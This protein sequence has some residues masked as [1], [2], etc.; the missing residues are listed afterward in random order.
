MSV[1]FFFNSAI[2]CFKVWGQAHCVVQNAL[3]GHSRKMKPGFALSLSYEGMSLLHRAAGGWRL[4]GDVALDSMDMAGDLAALRDKALLLE[5]GGLHCKIILP[6]DQIR[7]LSVETGHFNGEARDS[8]VRSALD[9][10]TPYA[11]DDLAYDIAEDGVWTHIAAVARETLAEAEAFA[12]DHQFNPVSFVAVPDDNRFL[13]EPFF[14]VTDRAASLPEEGDVEPDGIAVVVVGPAEI[15]VADIP[16][17]PVPGNVPESVPGVAPDPIVAGFTSRRKAQKTSSAPS[18]GGAKRDVPPPVLP[19]VAPPI[20]A[21]VEVAAAVDKVEP[22]ALVKPDIP[23][24]ERDIDPLDLQPDPAPISV[25]EPER[26]SEFE[27]DIDPEWQAE[28]G[29]EPEP[30]YE[31]ASLSVT[32]PTLDIPEFSNPVPPE[33]SNGGSVFGRFLSRRSKTGGKPPV[34]VAPPKQVDV[35]PNPVLAPVAVS[36]PANTAVI[37]DG[38]VIGSSQDE[39]DRMTV[40]GAR[41]TTKVGGKPRYLGLMLTFG[42]LLFLAGVAAWAAIFLDDGVAGLFRSAKDE[43]QLA[44][45]PGT[46]TI[47]SPGV[48]VAPAA[49]SVAPSAP[50]QPQGSDQIPGAT[51]EL[52]ALPPARVGTPELPDVARTGEPDTLSPPG[53]PDTFVLTDTDSAVLDA[54]NQ[55]VPP[56]TQAEPDL[57]PDADGI[58]VG[59]ETVAPEGSPEI[60]ARYAATGIWQSAPQEP[61]TPSIIG[62]N[63]L[64]V[65]SIDRTDIGQDAVALPPAAGYATDLA[66]NALSSPAAAGTAFDLNERGLVVAT[67]AG[68]L[69]PDG[70]MIFLGRPPVVPPTVPT[71]FETE[72]ETD[73]VRD[74]LASLRPRLRPGD[75]G[76]Q[77]ER[78]QLGG[79]TRDELSGLR[80]KARP[81]TIKQEVEK[82]ETPTAAAVAA[83]RLP[84]PRPDNFAA[85]VTKATPSPNPGAGDGG[86]AG[87]SVASVA[88]RTVTPSIPSSAS[89][90]RQA[91]LN[92]AINLRRVNLI[93][94]YG[95]PSNRRALVRLPSGRYKKVKV[96]DTVDGGRVV[97]IGDTELRYQKGGR[98]LTLKI[99]SG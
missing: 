17:D 80:P 31:P 82:D 98:N 16:P 10:A 94:V 87:Q 29:Q 91:T 95:T 74:R 45:V 89:V 28:F 6:N 65:A 42:L 9:G 54:L 13:G 75:L 49:V 92:N 51:T 44:A 61:D 68:T 46:P 3:D 83:S 48:A 27:E 55:P 63:D 2:S 62:L 37:G 4:V 32:A 81:N 12:V 40:F 26:A 99:P 19:A 93:G 58:E 1:V 39:A 84:K 14:G 41:Q 64:Y 57:E 21:S 67:A 76:Q 56:D 86:R 71:R 23:P 72:P 35:P 69:S 88:P 25:A 11:V 15:P 78:T 59:A 77:F 18:L 30:D 34:A 79:L 24:G 36:R 96:G 85:I 50:L 20:V 7:Y 43:P 70:V 33:P 22:G 60:V 52:A 38:K 53:Q 97:A 73:A 90:A 5:P 47:H 66:P 8:M